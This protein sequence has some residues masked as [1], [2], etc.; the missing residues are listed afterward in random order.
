MTTRTRSMS[1][2]ALTAVIAA[3]CT[4]SEID[5]P[6]IGKSFDAPAA[7]TQM[8]AVDGLL[9]APAWRSFTMMSAHFGLGAPTTAAVAGARELGVGGPSL[10]TADVRQ[11]AAASAARVLAATA[12][13]DG[14]GVPALPPHVKGTTFIWDATQHRYVAASG[15]SGA[16]TDGVRFVL[17]AVNP[18]TN[19]PVVAAEIGYADLTDIGAGRASGVGLRLQLVSG[20]MTYLD[21]SVIADGTETTGSLSVNGFLSDGATRLNF[22]ITARGTNAPG[23]STGQ[24]TFQFDIPDRAFSATGDVRGSESLGSQHVDL[25]V[26]VHDARIAFAV[27]SD[28][29]SVNASISVNDQLFATVTGD[30]H[31]PVVR[32]AGGRELR[33]DEAQ[34][35]GQMMGLADTAFRMLGDLLKPAEAILGPH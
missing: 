31:Q 15:R 33:P 19:E 21:Y 17:Y 16:P 8:Q 34:A 23:A 13:Q 32:G 26:R 4:G 22:Q 11:L 10:T 5:A 1:R 3:S 18:F 14:A 20:G 6:P 28:A 30:P 25:V 12:A 35:L 24:V 29:R 7:Q 2:C 27:E 9:G